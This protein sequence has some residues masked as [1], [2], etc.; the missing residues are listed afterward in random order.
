[1]QF[2][3]S[4]PADPAGFSISQYHLQ[5][6]D[7][8][9]TSRYYAFAANVIGNGGCA[10]LKPGVQPEDEGWL[11][12]PDTVSQITHGAV[13]S[14]FTLTPFNY[15][16]IEPELVCNTAKSITFSRT[17]ASSYGKAHF[18][19]STLFLDTTETHA[20]V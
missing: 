20:A 2:S 1:M 8:E 5:Y 13:G 12:G 17:G 3:C 14:S 18:N 4:P 6:E 19:H 16:G 11:S 15:P 7:P 9:L 10:S